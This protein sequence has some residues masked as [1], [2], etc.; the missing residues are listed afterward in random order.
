[1]VIGLALGLPFLSLGPH[2]R[3][4]IYLSS[5]LSHLL[6]F[7][8][9]AFLLSCCA[10]SHSVL[11]SRPCSHTYIRILTR[12]IRLLCSILLSL[13]S[14][15]SI[16]VFSLILSSPVPISLYISLHVPAHLHYHHTL[17]HS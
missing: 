12:C 9:V 15:S 14:H 6:D 10:R 5:T 11:L 3:H 8:L 17:H 16:A 1:M 13:S 7:I 2:E 4:A